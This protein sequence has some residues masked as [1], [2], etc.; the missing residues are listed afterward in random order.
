MGIGLSASAGPG[1]RALL[2]TNDS[3]RILS[4]VG[5]G[6]REGSGAGEKLGV[7]GAM[8][9]N[10]VDL[11]SAETTTG[12]LDTSNETF[13]SFWQVM[14]CKPE[15]SYGF[16]PATK[17]GISIHTEGAERAQN[18]S[19]S[20]SGTE[21][22][23]ATFQAVSHKVTSILPTGEQEDYSSVH[24]GAEASRISKSTRP[25][26]TKLRSSTNAQAQATVSALFD[27]S[28]TVVPVPIAPSLLAQGSHLPGELAVLPAANSVRYQPPSMP[29]KE[30]ASAAPADPAIAAGNQF[31]RTPEQSSTSPAGQTVAA[32]SEM[33]SGS[34]FSGPGNDS[35][36]HS[37]SARAILAG[38][39]NASADAVGAIGNTPTIS[40]SAAPPPK[41][42]FTGQG[43]A[44]DV[45]APNHQP[46]VSVSAG[47]NLEGTVPPQTA[48]AQ[49]LPM[50]AAEAPGPD[51]GE[52]SPAPAMDQPV[53]RSQAGQTAPQ[54]VRE[55]L[56]EAPE[57]GPGIV[58]PVA[59]SR[60]H[61]RVDG[62]RIR[63]CESVSNRLFEPSNKKRCARDVG[64]ARRRNGSWSARMDSR[65][66]PAR[67][68]RI[69]GSVAGLGWRARRPERGQRSR[70]VG[71]G[72]G[73]CCSGAERAHSGVER[74][75]RWGSYEGVDA[76]SY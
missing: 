37:L 61:A 63:A 7:A 54:A 73:R 60:W 64:R 33:P 9:T 6:A 45:S 48:A 2:G 31:T 36:L 72:I 5:V 35:T 55:V 21:E 56:V 18:P 47:F 32:A 26:S 22:M 53:R 13:R 19:A 28:V 67:R 15:M 17:P 30:P 70:D 49:V 14:L 23:A 59:A 41:T 74:L 57:A 58:G 76:D 39:P 38:D 8:R 71:A 44:T 20:V 46:A 42:L 69:S 27:L 1:A 75:P 51:R 43:L 29:P 65:G 16:L 52:R 25:D 66:S 4:G 40:Q 68:S 50:G 24:S 62:S 3:A 11:R 10:N 12:A 34:H